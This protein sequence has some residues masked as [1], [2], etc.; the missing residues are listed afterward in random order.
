MKTYFKKFSIL[1]SIVCI[2]LLFNGLDSFAGSED[3]PIIIRKKIDAQ[4]YSN[5]RPAIVN[6]VKSEHKKQTFSPKSD[7]AKLRNENKVTADD[8]KLRAAASV[9]TRQKIKP[10][11]PADKVDPF[12]PLFLSKSKKKQDVQDDAAPTHVIDE[13]HDKG[14]LENFEL[15]Q[16]KLTGIICASDRNIALVQEASGKGYV[17]NK[18][19]RIGTKGGK[20]SDILKDKI[21]VGEKMRDNKGNLF[22]RKTELKLTKKL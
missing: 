12:E 16:L 8:A 13:G 5:S 7:I 19:T 18:G 9:A 10:Y 15:S 3:K 21:I 11:V 4:N 22:I 1:F 20:V 2:A 14:P 17:I 6:N